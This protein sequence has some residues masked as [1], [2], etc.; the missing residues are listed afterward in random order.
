MNGDLIDAPPAG[1]V[2]FDRRTFLDALLAVGF[3]ST[4][5]AIA[6][7]VGLFLVPPAAGEPDT[8][9]VVAAKALELR[10]NSGKVFRFGSRPA[11]VVRTA[12]NELRVHRGVH[13]SRLHGAVQAG[14]L[15]AVVRLSQR[16]VRP[17][18]QRRFRPAAPAP[19]E[20][21]RQRPR[22]RDGRRN[23]RFARVTAMVRH[24]FTWL[25]ERF[26]LSDLKHFV[27][28]K[29]VPIHA[30]KVWYYLGGITLF[31]FAVQIVSGIL[32]L[33][34]YRPSA[35]EAY[36]SVQFIVT[37]VQFGW[38]IRNVHSWS[39]NLLI[40]AA[41]AHL[42]SVFLLKSYRKPRELTWI[43]GVLLLFLMLAF[44]FSGYLLPWN[45]LS[46]FATKV[47][48]GIAGAVPVVGHFLLRVLRGGDDVTGATLSRFYGFH[49]AVLPAITIT[50]VALHLLF[51]Q[52]QGMSV[53]IKTEQRLKAGERLRQMP[54]FPNYLLRDVLAWYVALAIVAAL[55]AFY[56]RELGTKA[57]PFA[58]V[59][60][61]IRPEWYFL[62]TFH[63]LKVLPSHILG[64][65]G[66]RLGIVA[67]GLAAAL[68]LFVPFLDRRAS[69]G[70]RS[71]VFTVVALLGL[72]YLVAFTVLGV[73]AR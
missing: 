7:P 49:V 30:Q 46:F 51:V 25:D 37:K 48:T 60:P 19:G 28:E 35:A 44:G 68:L 38:L 26:D 22:G 24:A 67:F 8:S 6:Y 2:R 16:H 69:R 63:T 70:E 9:S 10:P 17:Q 13:A 47:G 32:L 12:N 4:A 43:S 31:L 53:P 58:A 71:P 14:H 18:R 3:V 42:F 73:Y 23:C 27:A 45:E 36:E 29:G 61:G 62:A 66:E 57:D 50:L 40:A 52:R 34:Y 59:P 65:E 56:P 21:R 33:L 41:F 54:F 1:S 15:A 11:I 72:A 55:A 5:A 64:L 39:A 20:I